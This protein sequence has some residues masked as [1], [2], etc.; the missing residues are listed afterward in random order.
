MRADPTPPGSLIVT[1]THRLFNGVPLRRSSLRGCTLLNGL[2]PT[3]YTVPIAKF[4]DLHEAS[5]FVAT[6]PKG[7][8]RIERAR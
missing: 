6:L 2:P 5:C 1:R 4:V 3:H 7:D 8:Y